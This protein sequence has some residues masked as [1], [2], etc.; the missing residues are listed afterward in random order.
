MSEHSP[1]NDPAGQ[2]H[3]TE[4]ALPV[5]TRD[6]ITTEL[7][8]VLK[9]LGIV[10]ATVVVAVAAARLVQAFLTALGLGFG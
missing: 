10:A 9:L 1:G 5:S 6:S 7:L 8:R 2:R 3:E 4:E